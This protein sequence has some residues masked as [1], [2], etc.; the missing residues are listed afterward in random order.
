MTKAERDKAYYLANIE[1]QK[2]RKKEWYKSK[3][4]SDPSWFK[5]RG[6]HWRKS[7]P[8]S[9]LVITAKSRAKRK[10]LDF[11]ISI[12]DLTMPDQCPVLKIPLIVSDTGRHNNN[13]PSL[14][15]IDPTKGYIKGN[16]RV[17]SYRANMLKNNMS[18]EEARLI[19]ED[20]N[21]CGKL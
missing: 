20:L 6:D 16:V 18:V 8:L 21:K 19:L 12:E 1:K 10:G 2:Q 15:R 11:D 17:I 3:K 5:E 7:N 13:S 4:L 14:D 9:I